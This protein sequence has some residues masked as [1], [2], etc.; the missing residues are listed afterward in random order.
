MEKTQMLLDMIK[1]KHN[2]QEV[3]VLDLVNFKTGECCMIH[4]APFEDGSK[5]LKK[6]EK[7]FPCQVKIQTSLANTSITVTTPNKKAPEATQPPEPI[8]TFTSLVTGN[9]SEQIIAIT[10]PTKKNAPPKKK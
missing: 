4:T 6:G 1:E 2:Y 8:K 3:D 5:Y 10:D 9:A 7:Y